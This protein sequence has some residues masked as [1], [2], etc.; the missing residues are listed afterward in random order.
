[1]EEEL[2]AEISKPTPEKIE[3]FKQA[4]KA[5]LD[6]SPILKT[7]LSGEKHGATA[8]LVKKVLAAMEDV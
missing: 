8:A 6:E 1:M 5:L 7:F 4:V 3:A 2:R